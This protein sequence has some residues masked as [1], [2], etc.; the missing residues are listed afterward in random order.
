[1]A[2]LLVMLTDNRHPDPDVDRR[3]AFKR[4]HVVDVRP[5]GWHWGAKEGPP[6]FTVIRVPG[7]PEEYADLLEEEPDPVFQDERLRPRRRRVDLN[8]LPAAIRADLGRV[9]RH[10]LPSAAALRALV[11]TADG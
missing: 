2:E 3:H 8:A 11:R 6:R 1:M 9:R 7:P 5:D 10:A 4:G